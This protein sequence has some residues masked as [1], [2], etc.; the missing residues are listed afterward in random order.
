MFTFSGYLTGLG[1]PE[2][3]WTGRRQTEVEHLAQG[4]VERA[5]ASA[6]GRGER[7]F[8]AD[9]VV[10]E[11]IDGIIG[12]PCIKFF[13]GQSAC[14]YLEPGDFSVALVGL[15]NCGIEYPL[16][17]GPNIGT[18]PVTTNERDYGMVGYVEF[19]VYDL[20]FSAFRRGYR[21][22]FHLSFVLKNWALCRY[23]QESLEG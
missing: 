16:A 1:T 3:Y 6:D 5:D 13:F 9:Q 17:G 12:E 4:D 7:A 18:G 2:K 20:N 8:D 19:A 14:I 10:M 23:L 11:N 21:R 15:R 22:I